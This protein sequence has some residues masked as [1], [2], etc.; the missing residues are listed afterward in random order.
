M[1]CVASSF[2]GTTTRSRRGNRQ[3]RE[4]GKADWFVVKFAQTVA[5][6]EAAEPINKRVSCPG[7]VPIVLGGDRGISFKGRFEGSALSHRKEKP[8]NVLD[9]LEHVDRDTYV[10]FMSIAPKAAIRAPDNA[11]VSTELFE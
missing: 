11:S 5:G 7:T 6:N 1:W 10:P 4:P 9:V 3:R 8:D 2:L